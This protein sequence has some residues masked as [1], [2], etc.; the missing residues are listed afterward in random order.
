M[1]STEQLD[2]RNLLERLVS[3][4]I[5][6]QKK[7]KINFVENFKTKIRYDQINLEKDP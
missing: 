4:M 6:T 7:Y 5:I 1:L 3:I 2:F